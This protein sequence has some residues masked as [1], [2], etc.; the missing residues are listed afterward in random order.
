M[1]RPVLLNTL[2]VVLMIAILSVLVK[3]FI[4]DGVTLLMTFQILSCILTIFLFAILDSQERGTF[5]AD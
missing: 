5:W 3:G 1:P 2:Y 4:T